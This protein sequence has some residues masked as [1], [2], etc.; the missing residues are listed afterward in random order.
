MINVEASAAET[1][2][3]KIVNDATRLELDGRRLVLEEKK[4]ESDDK[5]AVMAAKVPEAQLKLLM[6]LA[7]KFT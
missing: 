2:R 5:K 3:M 1:K 7:G 6:Q 4:A